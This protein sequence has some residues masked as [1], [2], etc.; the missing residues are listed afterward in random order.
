M[1]RKVQGK[2]VEM[3]ERRKE[4]VAGER[5]VGTKVRKKKKAGRKMRKEREVNGGREVW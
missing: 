1:R 3:K 5:E 2:E 4:E